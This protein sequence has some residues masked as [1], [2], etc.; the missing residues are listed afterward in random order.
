MFHIIRDEL[1]LKKCNDN[2]HAKQDNELFI[3]IHN[4]WISLSKKILDVKTRV[5]KMS[6]SQKKNRNLSLFTYQIW[7]VYI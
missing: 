3:Y 1:K 6:V 2:M 7:I 4:Y 5:H